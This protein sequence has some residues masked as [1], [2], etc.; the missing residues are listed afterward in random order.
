MAANTIVVVIGAW[1]IIAGIISIGC[2]IPLKNS[3]TTSGDFY[4]GGGITAGVFALFGG[5]S[6]ILAG[7][8]ANRIL[9][10]AYLA[11]FAG[12][13]IFDV[14]I[15]IMLVVSA[16]KTPSTISSSIVNGTVNVQDCQDNKLYSVI[17]VA[18]C[19]F[20][21]ISIASYVVVILK[22]KELGVTFGN[23]P[24]MAR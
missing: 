11:L 3:V 5:V 7:I 14:V 1:A 15:A 12:Y 10:L 20:L 21:L 16:S 6:L 17:A 24:V 4:F 23:D 2:A 18:D 9:A 8:Q 22:R 13:L 19:I